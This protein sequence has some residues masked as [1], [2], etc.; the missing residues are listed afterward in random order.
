MNIIAKLKENCQETFTTHFSCLDI[1]NHMM[2]KCRGPEKEFNAC[3]FD[4]LVKVFGFGDEQYFKSA[5]S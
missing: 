1:N 5:L 4:K 3:V 2:Q